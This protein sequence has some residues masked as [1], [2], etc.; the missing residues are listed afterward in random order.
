M[1]IQQRKKQKELDQQRKRQALELLSDDTYDII[2]RQFNRVLQNLSAQ[3]GM[4]K[5]R[6]EYEILYKA[7]TRAHESEVRLLAKCADL[8]GEIAANATKVESAIQMSLNDQ[9]VIENL[10]KVNRQQ[11]LAMAVF[12]SGGDYLGKNGRACW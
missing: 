12:I 5:F 9:E 10:K 3:E 2:V 6:A 11:C 7:L 1:C 4:D 8:N